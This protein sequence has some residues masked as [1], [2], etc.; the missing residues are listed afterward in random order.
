MHNSSHRLGHEDNQGMHAIWKEELN[1]EH[2]S[3]YEL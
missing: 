2:S 3:E 1:K